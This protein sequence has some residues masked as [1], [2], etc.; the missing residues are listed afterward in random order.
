MKNVRLKFETPEQ[1]VFFIADHDGTPLAKLIIDI[2]ESDLIVNGMAALKGKRGSLRL[3][4]F[5]AMISYARE[6]YLNIIAIN[7]F[8]Y[9]K[10]KGDPEQYADVW[11]ENS[12]H[13][14]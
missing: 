4:L 14:E 11:D 9:N 8:V 3:K 2:I 12:N 6:H 5:H 7:R 13:K 1:A 10:L